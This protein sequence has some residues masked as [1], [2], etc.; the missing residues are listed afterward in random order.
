MLRSSLVL[1][2]V[3]VASYLSSQVDTVL[4]FDSVVI[5][6]LPLRSQDFGSNAQVF[7]AE[8]LKAIHASNVGELLKN[9]NLAFLKTY[10]P[11]TLASSSFRGG[12]AGQSLVLWNGL[13]LQSPMLGQLDFSLLPVSFADEIRVRQGGNSSLW[14]SGA[15]AGSISLEN[16]FR[17]TPSLLFDLEIGSFH[18]YKP[19]LQLRLG[20]KKLK[21]VTR[22]LYEKTR[23]NFPY[24]PFTGAKE[25]KLN[26]A[27]MT[28]MGFMQ[29]FEYTLRKNQ[30]LAFH[31]WHQDTDRQIP[32][33]L[34]QK[35]SLAQQQDK[36]TRVAFIFKGQKSRSMYEWKFGYF[37]EENNYRDDQ[38]RL[39]NANVFTT[40]MTDLTQDWTLRPWLKMSLGTTHSITGAST[41]A[42]LN[43]EHE[44]LGALFFS[45][46]VILNRFR[47]M[48]ALRKQWVGN[49]SVPLI[50]L[51]SF[52]YPITPALMIK[53][54]FSRDYRL[55][56]LND[57]F[58][59]PGGNP[60]L[61]AENGWSQE[62]TFSW[63]KSIKN[64]SWSCR[65]TGYNRLIHDWIIWA[66]KENQ[67]FFSPQ[68]INRVWSRGIEPFIEV[69]HSAA[70]GSILSTFQASYNL[71]K[72]TNQVDINNPMLSKGQQ[73]IYTPV[74][75]ASA[76]LSI[77]LDKIG[78]S[79][80]HFLTGNYE[81]INQ[82]IPGFRL[83]TVELNAFP[84]IF[85]QKTH[86]FI[87]ADNIWNQ[88]YQVI[89]N[90][91]MP[92]RNYRAGL[93]MQILY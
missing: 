73:L 34:T 38:I 42:Y 19:N 51:L 27:E 62:I 54:K 69:S 5:S 43:R 3:L 61:K 35:E 6:A 52:Q 23:N 70:N 8:D 66:R 13:P 67:S 81:G 16:H 88:T 18:S 56:T 68:N 20:R 55:P 48:A 53:G 71:I 7:D 64:W 15:V 90:R 37:A 47:I 93:K 14:G 44:Y 84:T 50:P 33:L 82:K 41:D 83:A 11:G 2:G 36:A 76:G 77:Q 91:P 40:W 32:P 79:Y 58:W 22:V 30:K 26:H 31:F 25:I 29:S 17:F 46:R 78:L 9:N 72:S 24:Q 28:Q 57:R 60:A 85:L 80:K 21:S 74:H 87:I 4:T 10:G 65:L 89:E 45:T 12:S 49:Q 92:G 1:L 39:E 59:V 86:L 63:V 75:Q